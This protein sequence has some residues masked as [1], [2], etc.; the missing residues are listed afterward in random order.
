MPKPSTFVS[1]IRKFGFKLRQSERSFLIRLGSD[2]EFVASSGKARDEVVAKCKAPSHMTRNLLLAPLP[3]ARSDL[4]SSLITASSFV[5]LAK[6]ERQGYRDKAARRLRGVLHAELALEGPVDLDLLDPEREYITPVADLEITFRLLDIHVQEHD[7][8]ALE[9][10]IASIAHACTAVLFNHIDSL[11]LPVYETCNY[12]DHSECPFRDLLRICLQGDSSNAVAM[13]I[14]DLIEDQI[15]N[16][17]SANERGFEFSEWLELGDGIDVER[18]SIDARF[19][20]AL[21]HAV[22]GR[23]IDAKPKRQRAPANDTHHLL[24]CEDPVLRISGDQVVNLSRRAMAQFRAGEARARARADETGEDPEELD[25]GPDYSEILEKLKKSSRYKNLAWLF[26]VDDATQAFA[27]TPVESMKL[28]NEFILSF[29]QAA[30]TGE[31]GIL[32]GPPRAISMPVAYGSDFTRDDLYNALA[33]QD[34]AL[35]KPASGFATPLHIARSWCSESQRIR[36]RVLDYDTPVSVTFDF[37]REWSLANSLAMHATSLYPEDR[38]ESA[39]LR[40]TFELCSLPTL[41]SIKVSDYLSSTGRTDPHHALM[42]W[43][44]RCHPRFGRDR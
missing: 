8:A 44:D 18:L 40:S 15:R 36:S 21:A 31:Y 26:L 30:W 42:L 1:Q 17:C 11:T 27:V 12:G 41:K 29:S 4:S 32:S 43:K 34:I 16:Y 38:G 19:E 20:K 28:T 14:L 35:E 7:A 24:I 23:K 33:R 13:N 9:S 25:W 6:W 10:T 22:F 39:K 5:R 2:V 37:L 3:S